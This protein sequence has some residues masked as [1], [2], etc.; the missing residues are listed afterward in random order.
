MR[1]LILCVLTICL[2]SPAWAQSKKELAAQDA[3]LAELREVSENTK[4]L[5]GNNGNQALVAKGETPF[6][7]SVTNEQLVAV[8]RDLTKSEKGVE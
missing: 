2:S 1:V 3:A 5:N 8:E 4:T 6:V 7:Q